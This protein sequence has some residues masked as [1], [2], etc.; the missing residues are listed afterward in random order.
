LA[1]RD[2]ALTA[3]KLLDN[4]ILLFRRKP[5]VLVHVGDSLLKI[6]RMSLQLLN[7]YFVRFGFKISTCQRLRG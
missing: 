4:L 6:I 1:D 2:R 5:F 3:D 7:P